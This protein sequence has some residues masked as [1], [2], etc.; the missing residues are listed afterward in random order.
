M[1]PRQLASEGTGGP[2]V[3]ALTNQQAYT[4][5]RLHENWELAEALE[6]YIKGYLDCARSYVRQIKCVLQAPNTS[7]DEALSHQGCF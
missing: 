3:P 6:T 2:L 5:L 1:A 4:G 7:S